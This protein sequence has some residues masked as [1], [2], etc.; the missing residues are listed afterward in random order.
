MQLRLSGRCFFPA[1]AADGVRR[2][3]RALERFVHGDLPDAAEI[4]DRHDGVAEEHEHEHLDISGRLHVEGEPA[5]VEEHDLPPG[6]LHG[7]GAEPD[8]DGVDEHEHD[9]RRQ[10]VQPRDLPVFI[11]EDVQQG[12]LARAGR[13]EQDADLAA[14]DR[15]RHPTQ[16]LLPGLTAAVA[17]FQV[18]DLQKFVF[19]CHDILFLCKRAGMRMA[20][21]KM[22]EKWAGTVPGVCP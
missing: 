13:A 2:L 3:F 9:R 20:S 12:G 4:E 5:A 14:R 7:G 18:H 17:L 19:F 11:A 8:A 1:G 10:Q 21:P 6:Q 22:A 15:K 16:D